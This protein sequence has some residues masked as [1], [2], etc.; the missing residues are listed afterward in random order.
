MIILK[1][2]LLSHFF[3]ILFESFIIYYSIKLYIYY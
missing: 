1:I 2:N 3:I